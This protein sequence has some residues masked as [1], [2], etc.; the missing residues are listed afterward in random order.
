MRTILH[1]IFKN[2]SLS[3]SLLVF[4]ALVCFATTSAI[5]QVSGYVF[6]DYD[7]NGKRT[8][9][10]PIEIGV[11]GVKVQLYVGNNA[12]PFTTFTDST[13]VYAFDASKALKD[14]ILRVEFSGFPETFSP[15]LVGV[16]SGTEVQFVKAPATNVIPFRFIVS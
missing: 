1:L 13:G 8:L 4:L 10:T 11:S 14:S 12:T 3:R 2:Q 9:N 6:F 15:T 5:G 7:A 16:N